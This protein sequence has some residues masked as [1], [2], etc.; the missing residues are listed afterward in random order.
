MAGDRNLVRNAI[1]AYFGGSQPANDPTVCF[2]GGPLVSYGLGTAYPYSVRGVPDEYYTLGMP[3]GQNWGA[4]LGIT[5]VERVTVRQAYGGATSG[6]RGR[7]YTIT[8]ELAVIAE[9]PYIEVAGAGLD[10]LIDQMHAL[11]YADRTLGT[12]GGVYNSLV[13]GRL[14]QQ[15][16]EG[17]AGIRDVTDRFAGLDPDKGRYAGEATVTFEALTMIAA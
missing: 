8:C 16:G 15:A 4:V 14:I 6:W 3:A 5:R 13:N 1:A 11:I 9:L 12:T 2:Q 7:T 10:N 17:R